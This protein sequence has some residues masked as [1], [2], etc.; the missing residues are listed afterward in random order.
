MTLSLWALL[1]GAILFV[2]GVFLLAARRQAA[3]SV[4]GFA[5]HVWAGRVLSTLAW[6]WAG[7]ALYIMPLELLRPIRQWIPLLVLAAVPLTWYWMADLL[8][9]RAVGGLLVLFPA[10]LL[11]AAREEPSPLRLALV[12]FTYVAIIIGMGLILYPYYLRRWLDWCA[13]RPGRL[14]GAGSVSL[15]LGLFF[16]A[17]GWLV[18][19]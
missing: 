12:I 7:W 6:I 13:A 9:C 1:L 5:R 14:Q 11:L 15:A 19:Q 3:G 16:V 2:N 4:R 10:P 17:L 18:F 8:S